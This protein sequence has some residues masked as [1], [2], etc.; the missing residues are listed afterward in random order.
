MYFQLLPKMDGLFVS[1]LTSKHQYHHVTTFPT[2]TRLSRVTLV[3]LRHGHTTALTR[4][5]QGIPICG[6]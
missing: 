4:N 5:L 1:T 2:M 6:S 3:H